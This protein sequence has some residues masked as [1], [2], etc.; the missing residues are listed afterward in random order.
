[1]KHLNMNTLSGANKLYYLENDLIKTFDD[2]LW[3]GK[4]F[5]HNI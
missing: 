5:D 2:K 1:M 3:K 4:S